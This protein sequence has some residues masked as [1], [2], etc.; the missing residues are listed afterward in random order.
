MATEAVEG[1]LN[2]IKSDPELTA[3]EFQNQIRKLVHSTQE[4]SA[5]GRRFTRFSKSAINQIALPE[6][7][8]E[9]FFQSNLPAEGLNAVTE[10][11]KSAQKIVKDS[12]KEFVQKITKLLVERWMIQ[13]C[14]SEALVRFC[15]RS[16]V[17]AET[18]NFSRNLFSIADNFQ[19]NHQEFPRFILQ[20]VLLTVSVLSRLIRLEEAN[21]EVQTYTLSSAL[22]RLL[23]RLFIEEERFYPYFDS[24][25]EILVSFNTDGDKDLDPFHHFILTATEMSQEDFIARRLIGKIL[26]GL[27]LNSGSKMCKIIFLVEGAT[28]SGSPAT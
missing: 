5:N 14:C 2:H 17:Q 16:S 19:L 20:Q 22:D 24:E 21:Y 8:E 11:T 3:V 25:G 12:E 27:G 6:G 13:N 9:L 28:N 18:A 15:I 26:L 10:L 7:L 23:L 4:D 1:I